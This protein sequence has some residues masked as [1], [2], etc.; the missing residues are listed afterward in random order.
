MRKVHPESK[1]RFLF[2]SRQHCYQLLWLLAIISLT[3]WKNYKTIPRPVGIMYATWQ[4]FKMDTRSQICEV[5]GEN[6]TSDSTV[7]RWM[8]LVKNCVHDNGRLHTAN[9]M[10]Q[11]LVDLDWEQID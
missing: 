10:Q 9:V 1:F 6:A 11:L 5:C 4:V 2:L 7:R 8:R 3:R